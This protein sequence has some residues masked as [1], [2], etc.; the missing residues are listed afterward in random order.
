MTFNLPQTEYLNPS[1]KESRFAHYR[2]VLETYGGY[3]ATAT[4][5]LPPDGPVRT[6]TLLGFHGILDFKLC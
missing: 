6:T 2:Q 5:S 1:C 4:P 3:P